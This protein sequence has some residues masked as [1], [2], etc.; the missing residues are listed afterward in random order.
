M[1]KIVVLASALIL[2]SGVTVF[3][4]TQT[5]TTK[6]D[7]AKP[8]PTT[9]AKQEPAKTSTTTMSKQTGEKQGTSLLIPSTQ[10]PKAAQDYLAKTYPDKKVDQAMKVTGANGTVS[11]AAEIG[12]MVFHFDSAGKFIQETKKEEKATS[13]NKTQTTPVKSQPAP[14]AKTQP[15]APAKK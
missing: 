9:T 1:K 15:A 13:G 2:A 10:L 12:S 14:A 5:T 4:Q 3:G 7:A 6:K 8:A 11:Y